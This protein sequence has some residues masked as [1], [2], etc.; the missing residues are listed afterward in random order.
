M[1]VN[2]KMTPVETV[3][4]MREIKESGGGVSSSMIY[5]IYYKNF[6]KCHNVPLLSTIKYINGKNFCF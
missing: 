3:P 1:Y 5:L 2:G 6:C 4:G